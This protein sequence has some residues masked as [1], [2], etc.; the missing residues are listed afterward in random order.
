[1]VCRVPKPLA[2]VL[3]ALPSERRASCRTGCRSACGGAPSAAS[4]LSPASAGGR[5][6]APIPCASPAMAEAHA[7][8]PS[9]SLPAAWALTVP[10]LLASAAWRIPAAQAYPHTC[11]RGSGVQSA[12]PASAAHSLAAA[13]GRASVAPPSA[14]D[15]QD[16]CTALA[17]VGAA[18]QGSTV[19]NQNAAT[20]QELASSPA[21]ADQTCLPHETA[22][23]ARVSERRRGS[24]AS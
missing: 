19:W 4:T 21:G 6:P 7:L 3:S 12:A 1:M 24:D 23:A 20:E 8:A 10:M 15:E 9:C 14:E 22:Q 17:Q 16:R 5:V 2:P 13:G 18:H 11:S